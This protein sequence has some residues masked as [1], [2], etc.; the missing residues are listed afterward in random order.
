MHNTKKRAKIVI[1]AGG[2]GHFTPA[3]AVLELLGKGTEVAVIGRKYSLEGDKALSLE[4]QTV[5]D[6]NIP[7]V[8]LTTGRLQRKFTRYTI[9]SLLKFPLGLMQAYSFLRSFQPD[10]VLSFGGYICVPVVIAA[11]FLRI[12][13]VVHE[14]TLE[15]GVANRIAS[16]FAEKVCISWESSRKFFR[17]SKVVLTGNP[18][19]EF[20]ISNPSAGEQFPIKDRDKDLPMIYITGG[21]LGSHAIN[22]LVEG[23]IEKLLG[24]YVVLHQTGDASEFHDFDRLTKV[25]DTLSGEMQKRYILKKFINASEVGSILRL[26]DLVVARSGITTVTELLFFKKPSLLIPLPFSQR[27]EQ[28]KNALFLR[29]CGLAEVVEQEALA[30]DKL[31]TH[32]T[33]MFAKI[34]TYKRNSKKIDALFQKNAAAELIRVLDMVRKNNT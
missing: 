26:A 32:I 17:K 15:A 16:F 34:E 29:D 12:P 7:F 11:Y 13:I 21:S 23:C 6:L 31:Y 2:G 8:S 10:V 3:L 18:I 27:N 22:V 30:A 4:Y 25:R 20:P 24:K 19:R 5:R 1:T 28:L 14:Q 33:H 9:P